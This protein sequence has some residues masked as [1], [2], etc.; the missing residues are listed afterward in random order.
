M[1][2]F[3]VIPI[4]TEADTSQCSLTGDKPG[5]GTSEK[6]GFLRL[7]PELRQKVYRELLG[8]GKPGAFQTSI[9]RVS[10][11]IHDEA[12]NIFYGENGFIMYH[13][14]RKVSDQLRPS[15]QGDR[16]DF[17]SAFALY[18]ITGADGRIG[19]EVAL[20]VSIALQHWCSSVPDS[21]WQDEWER[22]VGFPSGLSGFCKALTSCHIRDSL[23][24][25]LSIPSM[26]EF[27]TSEGRL[28]TIL[29]DCFQECRGV[30][31]AEIFAAGGGGLPV[32]TDLSSL[33]T[34]PLE[35]FD[36][37]LTR[38]RYYQ[39]RV[40]QQLAGRNYSA[41]LPTLGRAVDF[42][43]WW[44]ANNVE[45]SNETDEKWTEFWDMKLEMSLLYAFQWLEY[46]K[47]KKARDEM[48][49]IFE[50]YPLK[51]EP[52]TD[53]PRRLWDKESEGHYITGLAFLAEGNSISALYSF[54]HALVSKPGH[55]GVDKEI[56]K[57]QTT[58]EKSDDPRDEII[59][60]NIKY[61][62][63]NFRH[64]PPLEPSLDADIHQGPTGMTE[65]DLSTHLG[66]FVCPVI[67]RIR[68]QQV[69]HPT[70]LDWS[71]IMGS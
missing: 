28:D 33:M 69:G 50:T 54:F 36:E 52:G 24:L 42:F 66:S 43:N 30:G 58:V 17:A 20:N 53:P 48:A 2:Y 65:H 39:D 3:F 71:W 12:V 57:M 38:G 56:D 27:R 64:Q 60:W 45:L 16:S 10:K 46:G 18:P 31:T 1:L 34:K 49:R 26:V 5:C 19:S 8:P 21:R 23:H 15:T 62:L 6:T 9:L 22:Y 51:R 63:K 68:G 67:Y 7:P 44:I 61:V 13:V 40:R 55:E 37:I 25:R 35:R 47:P 4:Y 32:E 59:R 29:L 41:A 70:G 14:H 11:G